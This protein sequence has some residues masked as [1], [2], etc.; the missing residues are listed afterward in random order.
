[1]I[2]SQD[3]STSS[4][5][6][7][8]DDRSRQLF[9]EAPLAYHEIDAAGIIRDVNQAE[10]QL[11]GYT[12]D[13]L[14]G[15]PVWT[16]LAAEHLEIARDSIARKITR[17]L[18]LSV[19]TREYRRADG[20]YVWLEIHEKLI[21]NTE[22]EVLGIRS[23][24]FDITERH[25][26]AAEIQK[27]LEWNRLVL[28]SIGRAVIATDA[29]GTITFMNPAAEALTGW[30]LQDAL[31]LALEH[32]CRVPHNPDKTADLMSSILAEP[33]DSCL[34]CKLEVMH[35]SGASYDVASTISPICTDDG[36]VTGAVLIIE[37]L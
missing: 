26:L 25:Q 20:T 9:A 15:H 16:F 27:R 30:L 10:C 17:E 14:I 21:E 1:M 12:R 28:R 37:K 31:G 33:S 5:V 29:L 24:S 4:A 2:N 23:A 3:L 13:Q 8:P 34:L 19:I 32:I 36:A 7:Q 18:P 6:Q 35:R 11:L 22:G